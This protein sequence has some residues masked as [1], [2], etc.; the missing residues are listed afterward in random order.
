MDLVF[1]CRRV[2]FEQEEFGLKSFWKDTSLFLSLYIYI[3]RE[4][5]RERLYTH[6]YVLQKGFEAESF[7]HK[8]QHPTFEYKIYSVEVDLY[9]FKYL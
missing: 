3:E 7:T 9:Y 8:Y 4:I 5:Y 6:T 1:D 2:E